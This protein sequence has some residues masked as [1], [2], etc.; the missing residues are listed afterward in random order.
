MYPLVDMRQDASLPYSSA[1]QEADALRAK[2]IAGSPQYA[3]L[4]SGWQDTP[5]TPE[6]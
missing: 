5:V 1:Y 6:L 4:L 2:L 3:A